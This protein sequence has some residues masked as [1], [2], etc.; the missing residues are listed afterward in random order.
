MP[1]VFDLIDLPI[2]KVDVPLCIFGG[3][4]IVCVQL[5]AHTLLLHGLKKI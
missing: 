3:S 1:I 2:G 4:W 5:K